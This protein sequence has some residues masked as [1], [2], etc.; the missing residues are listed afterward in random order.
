[1]KD[2]NGTEFQ[3]GD[4]VRWHGR[5]CTVLKFDKSYPSMVEIDDPKSPIKYTGAKKTERPVRGDEVEKI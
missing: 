1:M 3:I 4:K 5:E 2:K